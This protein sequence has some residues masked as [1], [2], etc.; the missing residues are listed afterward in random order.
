V[1]VDRWGHREDGEQRRYTASAYIGSVLAMLRRRDK[2]VS[3]PGGGPGTGYWSYNSPS[4]YWARPPGP[5]P[6][7]RL[8]FIEWARQ[9]GRDPSLP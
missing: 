5:S 1:L 9:Q 8:T 2:L 7:H 3:L 6:N 4:S